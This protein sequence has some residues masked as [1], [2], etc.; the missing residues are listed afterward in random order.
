MCDGNLFMEMCNGLCVFDSLFNNFEVLLCV[1]VKVF[2]WVFW[3]IELYCYIFKFFKFFR[4][5]NMLL[6]G[7]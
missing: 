7:R 6:F 2:F 3:R 4:N 5:E 1:V